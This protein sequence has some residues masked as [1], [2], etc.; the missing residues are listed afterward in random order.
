[1]SIKKITLL[2]AP[3]LVLFSLSGG[4]SSLPP[5]PLFAAGGLYHMGTN[6]TQ[7]PMLAVNTERRGNEHGW[8]YS[9]DSAHN[10][11]HGFSYNGAFPGVTCLADSCIG[12]G[13]YS[14]EFGDTYPM[15]AVSK[16][17]FG[18]HLWDYAI[19]KSSVLPTGYSNA[20]FYAISCSGDICAAVGEFT[21]DAN[22]NV[23]PMLAV[24]LRQGA[25][26]SWRFINVTSNF[27]GSNIN[28]YFNSVSCSEHICI[29]G[30][31]N[32]YDS[33]V[34]SDPVLAVNTGVGM[35]GTWN[36]VNTFPADFH[37]SG[38][39]N[40]FE[41]VACFKDFCIA[42]GS[43]NNNPTSPT[44]QYPMLAVNSNVDGSGIWQYR[45]DGTTDLPADCLADLSNC[46][47]IIDATSCDNDQCAVAGEYSIGGTH[48]PMLAI[49]VCAGGCEWDYAIDS[50]FLPSCYTSNGGFYAV[51]CAGGN[52]AAA[53]Q[54]DADDGIIYPLL[55]VSTKE[56]AVGSWSYEIDSRGFT[57]PNQYL[58]GGSFY[59]VT[60][61]EVGMCI[62][63]GYYTAEN[64]NYYPMLAMNKDVTHEGSWYYPIDSEGPLP[65][66]F[67]GYGLFCGSLSVVCN[68]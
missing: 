65:S 33:G 59:G 62:T 67:G 45:I 41:S 47:G 21:N 17:R 26:G 29:A 19:D 14:D 54:Y 57:L 10:L 39:L 58:N 53:G 27:P 3:V 42:G 18:R 61:N 36:F 7:F 32:I 13:A 20:Q 8:T 44:H 37:S 55:A 16:E 28:A 40:S 43:Y 5:E 9:I 11:P 1:M 50:S 56:G 15:I 31:Q 2:A 34:N 51:S 22:N 35:G 63:E 52:C 60:C 6:G 30:G 68:E 24:S 23:Y 49:N 48:Y 4:A 12:V 38:T 66:K 64:G 46:A 25:I